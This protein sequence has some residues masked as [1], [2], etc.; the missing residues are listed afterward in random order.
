V[1]DKLEFFN[2]LKM[3]KYALPNYNDT[4]VTVEFLREVRKNQCY[5][6]HLGMGLDEP[7]THPPSAEVVK[8]EIVRLIKKKTGENKFSAKERG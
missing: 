2:T 8:E 6:P 4:I 3:K 7:C 1:P 5:C